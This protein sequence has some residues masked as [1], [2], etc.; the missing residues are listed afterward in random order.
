MTLS[1][2]SSLAPLST[3]MALDFA[4]GALLTPWAP[5]V[6]PFHDFC[7]L[8]DVEPRGKGLVGTP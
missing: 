5:G 2:V 1:G 7:Y 8:E 4:R 6:P 3:S